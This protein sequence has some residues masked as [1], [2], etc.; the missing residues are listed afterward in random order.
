M[1][2]AYAVRGDL[3][4]DQARSNTFTL[5]WPKGS[6]TMREFPEVD[7]VGWFVVAQART[8]LLKGQREFLDRLMA[9]PDLAG[10]DEGS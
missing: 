4:I 10:F 9:H 7:R 8:K 3:E 2:T 5:E 1:V 6:G